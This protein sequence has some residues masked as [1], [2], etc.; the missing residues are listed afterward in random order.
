MGT[1][2]KCPKISYTKVSDKMAYA[3]SADPDQTAPEGAVQSG[4]ALFASPL[5]ILR[6]NGIR[7]KFKPKNCGM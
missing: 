3:N 7:A 4:S 5:N 2:G 1:Y 6:I